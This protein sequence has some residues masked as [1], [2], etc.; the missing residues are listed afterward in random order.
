MK[1]K[2]STKKSPTLTKTDVP[3]LVNVLRG[4]LHED[5]E[6][7]YGSAVS[8]LRAFVDDASE[9][10]VKALRADLARLI[11][12]ARGLTPLKLRRLVSSLGGAWAPAKA[13]EV[14]ALLAAI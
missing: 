10:E 11:E 5:Y 4:Y 6:A 3:M 1:K 8:A 9:D 12:D 2:V 13:A 14:E 7:E